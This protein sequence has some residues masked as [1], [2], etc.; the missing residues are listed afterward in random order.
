MSIAGDNMGVADVDTP[1]LASATITLTDAKAG[2]VLDYS[3]V[4]SKFTV[5][6]SGNGN[7]LTLTPTGEVS[8]G[9]FEEAIKAVKFRNTSEDPDPGDRTINVQVSD[10][11]R[12]MIRQQPRVILLR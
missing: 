3:G 10:G 9:D 7:T 12:S 6:T 11:N 8:H 5:S 2:D 1:N 4:G